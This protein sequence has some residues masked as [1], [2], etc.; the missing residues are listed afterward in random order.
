VTTP[1]SGGTPSI[2]RHEEHPRPHAAWLYIGGVL[3]LLVAAAAVA[4]FVIRGRRAVQNESRVRNEAVRSGAR[5]AFAEVRPSPAVRHISL[6]G[7]ARPWISTTLFGKVAGYLRDIRVDR[8]DRVRRGQILG[9][10]T[11]PEIDQQYLA[12]V[13]ER[14]IRE[15][16]AQ[17][18][19]ALVPPGA[20]AR[21]DA[22]VAAANAAVAR[23]NVAQFA[24]QRGYEVLRAP[25]DGVVT[26][27]YAD[28][29]AL[30]QNASGAA[31][32]ALPLVRVSRLDRLRVFV[33][34][35]QRNAAFVHVGDAAELALP[36][37]P[38]VRLR[39]AIARL[40]GEIEP[41]T[42]TMV[43]E[44]DVDNP[45]EELLAGGFVQVDL[46]VHAES[47]PEVPS[48]A[49]VMRGARTLLAVITP[50]DRI[51]MRAVTIV[52]DDGR[53]ARVSEGVR[54]GERVAVN[55]DDSTAEGDRVQPVPMAPTGGGAAGIGE[56][57]PSRAHAGNSSTGGVRSSP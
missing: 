21:Q 7:E 51:T 22:D 45:H 42:R 9:V 26:A 36:E 31:S 2:P 5:V 14:N 13:R 34:L 19:A 50:D 46:E 47:L 52:D 3:V 8:G 16:T 48:A 29:G 41:R 25:F 53:V 43:A 32:G 11:S 24:S 28:P 23:A 10:V 20:V 17:R 12:A 38:A 57:G 56:G 44:I 15:L 49:L 18:L 4:L 27:R 55:L 6:T 37:R 54:L 40:S 35:D 39:A 33:Y 30:V 1:E